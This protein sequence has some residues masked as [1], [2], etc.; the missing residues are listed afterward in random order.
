MPIYSLDR[1]ALFVA[2]RRAADSPYPPL[3][4]IHGAGGTHLDWPPALRRPARTRVI[5]LDLPGHGRSAPPARTDTR[6]YADDVCALLDAL[7]VGHAIILGHSM[8]GAV[9]QHVALTRPDLTAG[10][11]LLGT[12]SS[13]PISPTLLQRTIDNPSE[14]ADW[15]IEQAWDSAIPSELKQLARERLLANSPETLRADLLACQ[16]FDTRDQ[17]AAISVPALVIGAAD[18]HMVQPDLSQ[19]LAAAMPQ[20]T[21]VMLTNAGHMFPLECADLVASIIMSWLNIRFCDC[22][23]DS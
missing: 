7:A 10:L 17:A 3:V 9:A 20:A 5:A 18:D 15:M 23:S 6:A 16:T 14:A 12:G 22:E 2:E 4:L 13:L 19:E 1:A 8:G 11:I 21:L